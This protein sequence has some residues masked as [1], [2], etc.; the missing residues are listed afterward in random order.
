M[1]LNQRHRRFKS[2]C[3]NIVSLSD[4]Q[5]NT[6]LFVVPGLHLKRHQSTLL[7]RYAGQR[8][9]KWIVYCAGSYPGP[10]ANSRVP[11][12]L[13]NI[14]SFSVAPLVLV[15]LGLSG[16]SRVVFFG[17]LSARQIKSKF[18]NR[19][20]CLLSFILPVLAYRVRC[21]HPT[22]KN[23]VFF[24]NASAFLFGSFAAG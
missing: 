10:P 1:V 21:S 6:P 12:T 11:S 5:S 2:L 23:S 22:Y 4:V 24:W 17:N 3:E 19:G 9:D 8:M 15:I 7:L 18:G 14:S 13:L 16:F 20:H